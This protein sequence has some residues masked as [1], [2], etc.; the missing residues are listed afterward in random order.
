MTIHL[1]IL[2][3]VTA[4][5][6]RTAADQ[7]L[8][9]L[10]QKKNS[11]NINEW[12]INPFDLPGLNQIEI[13]PQD[14]A[15]PPLSFFQDN[16][17]L[18]I[19]NACPGPSS[20]FNLHT[21]PVQRIAFLCTID[22]QN[23]AVGGYVV[24]RLESRF[25]FD[26]LDWEDQGK[27][28]DG[29]G[30]RFFLPAQKTMM[31][32]RPFVH[33][34]GTF[35]VVE[36]DDCRHDRT[37]PAELYF[38]HA[39]IF[40]QVC[41]EFDLPSSMDVQQSV[42]VSNVDMALLEALRQGTVHSDKGL[43]DVQDIRELFYQQCL[44]QQ[45]S[46]AAW[47]S[48]GAQELY[49]F[50][51]SSPLALYGYLEESQAGKPPHLRMGTIS[52]KYGILHDY[53]YSCFL[54]PMPLIR[55][56]LDNRD[57]FMKLQGEGTIQNVARIIHRAT[58]IPV[59]TSEEDLWIIRQRWEGIC[60]TSPWFTAQYS[61]L[62]ALLFAC[63]E[64]PFS[65]DSPNAHLLCDAEINKWLAPEAQQEDFRKGLWTFIRGILN[66]PHDLTI[67]QTA[68]LLQICL[69]QSQTAN[70]VFG[71]VVESVAIGDLLDCGCFEKGI[72]C[73]PSAIHRWRGTP[74]E[75]HC[76]L[77][78]RTNPEE[79]W[80]KPLAGGEFSFAWTTVLQIED[81]IFRMVQHE[82]EYKEAV[83]YC[84]LSPKRE[85]PTEGRIPPVVVS[86]ASQPRV[87]VGVVDPL[88]ADFELCEEFY[89]T[90]TEPKDQFDERFKKTVA[91]YWK[92]FD[93]SYPYA[94]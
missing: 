77:H 71:R 42:L 63:Q 72:Q 5:D 34:E 7:L 54:Q 28:L 26:T 3:Q 52:R 13:T 47:Q 70:A 36:E 31:I 64:K 55:Q 93:Q 6:S 94:Y 22:K 89:S 38:A 10:W 2:E 35:T 53:A 40:D 25:I 92:M 24:E 43:K 83:V 29:R 23:K 88:S 51:G 81:F 76:L 62:A 12:A 79:V 27:P 45:Q 66:D 44:K 91:Q 4:D 50:S 46:S 37:E 85:C 33:H 8:L 18:D 41:A 75:N 32:I 20:L 74:W 9:Y 58:G 65:L 80:R 1:P 15:F 17:M 61:R 69:T 56:Y 86:C 30:I 57:L 21:G 19:W 16:H 84:C 48:T 68:A 67:S 39:A 73:T 49:W 60:L 90:L 78:Y 82:N 59:T 14:D 11:F 87:P